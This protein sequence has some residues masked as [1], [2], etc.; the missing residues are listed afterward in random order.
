MKQVKQIFFLASLWGILE[1]TLGWLLHFVHFPAGT[2]MFPIALMILLAGYAVTG[3]RSTLLLIG[4][5]AAAIKLSNIMLPGS[6]FLFNPT[7]SILVET[8]L[9]ALLA[10]Y[11]RV[12]WEGLK[13]SFLNREVSYVESFGLLMLAV[14]MQLVF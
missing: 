5:I 8:L 1:A 13:M 10:P 14:G 12:E 6:A 3:K 7:M 4:V 11:L 2:V 9:V